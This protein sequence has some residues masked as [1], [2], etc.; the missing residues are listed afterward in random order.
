MN[1]TTLD[2]L[3]RNDGGK[4][5]DVSKEAGIE[6]FAFGLGIKVQD[7]NMDGYPDIYIAKWTPLPIHA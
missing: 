6:K 7:I 1:E 4:F 2:R 3:Y 5:T